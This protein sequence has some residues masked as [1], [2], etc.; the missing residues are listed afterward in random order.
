MEDA[1]ARAGRLVKVTNVAWGASSRA[2]TLG[3]TD[4]LTK[5]IVDPESG[6]LLGAGIVGPP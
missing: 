2:V 3:R 4:G 5:L 6:R 1:A